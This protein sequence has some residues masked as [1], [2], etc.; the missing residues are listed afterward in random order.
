MLI[1]QALFLASYEI[2]LADSVE[3]ADLYDELE[4]KGLD[5]EARRAAM[6]PTYAKLAAAKAARLAELRA[7]L[8]RG[9]E[10]LH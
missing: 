6:E 2:D 5:R 9:G 10:S 8:M 3:I 1:E 7:E 4:A